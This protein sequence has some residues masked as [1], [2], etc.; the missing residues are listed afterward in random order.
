MR[1]FVLASLLSFFSVL[2]WA[3]QEE[4]ESD[5]LLLPEPTGEILPADSVPVSLY[6]LPVELDYIPGNETPELLADRLSCIQQT[7][8][9]TYNRTVH[10]FIDYF[11]VRNREY[12]RSMQRKQDMFFPLFEQKL[13]EYNLPDE[14]KYLSIIESALN[15]K[16]VSKAR[17]VG[18]WQFMSGTGRYMGLHL[19]WY[20]DERMDPEKSTDAA[21]RYLAQ[22][23]SIFNDWELA[24]AAYNSGPGTVKKAIRRSGYKKTFWEIYPHLPRETRSYVPQFIAM[25][26]AMNYA[27]QHNMLELTREELPTYDTLQ[28]KQFVHFEKLAE[29]TNTCLEDLQKLNP[30]MQRN[31]VPENGK[32]HI[33]KIPSLA[34]QNLELNRVAILDSVSRFGKKEAQLLATKYSG[35]STEGRELISYRV[36]SGDVL[37]GIAMRHRVRVSDIKSWNNLRSDN[38]H[39]GQRLA[40]WVIP[41]QRSVATASTKTVA[42]PALLSPDTK[43]YTVQPGDTLWDISRKVPGLTVEKIKKLNNLKSNSLQPGQKLIIS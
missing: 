15:P 16:A 25:I 43:T 18:L 31:V 39:T 7:I 41:S 36:K 37:G 30:S 42:Q 8:P 28:V 34:K 32:V 2:A 10:G 21:C 9:L 26:Y 4:T 5:T 23:Y 1:I 6:M 3:Q 17:A 38:I 12:T 40:I 22:L 29:L 20:I 33:M 11:T 27:E 14:L 24:L 19:D 13:K 35:G